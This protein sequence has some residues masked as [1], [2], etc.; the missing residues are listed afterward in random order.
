MGIKNNNI[1]RNNGYN[2]QVPGNDTQNQAYKP[3][4]SLPSIN[5]SRGRSGIEKT[6]F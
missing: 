2:T 1:V 4:I 3:P 6:R 5:M